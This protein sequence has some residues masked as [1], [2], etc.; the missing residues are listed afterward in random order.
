MLSNVAR[1]TIFVV[2]SL[3]SLYIAFTYSPLKDVDVASIL[4]KKIAAVN[5]PESDTLI[6][7]GE[8]VESSSTEVIVA[9][10][11]EENE[12]IKNTT[13]IETPKTA[14]TKEDPYEVLETSH[15]DTDETYRPSIS[16]CKTPMRYAFGTFDPRFNISKEKLLQI[17]KEAILVWEAAVG[18]TLFIYDEESR[19]LTINLIYDERQAST[20][21]LGYLALE[22]SNT[23]EVAENIRGAYEQEKSSYVNDSDAFNEDARR[24]Q[25]RYAAYNE[26]VK[27]YNDKGGATKVEYDAMMVELDQLK[28]DSILF[29]SRRQDLLT[30][31]EQINAKVKRYNELVAYVNTLIRKSNSMGSRTFTEGRF[32][33]LTNT[34]DIYQYSDETKLKRVLMHE[35]GHA[36]G[37]GHVENVASVMY[38]FNSGT[39][40]LLSTEDK[41]ALKEV[42]PSM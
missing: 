23:K 16:P 29:E 17:T 24:F 35:L 27:N 34:I 19:N 37:I 12:P 38:S 3:L 2:L 22:I 11:K 33:P 7:K 20:V 40:T 8:P 21:N 26:K 18:K 6:L 42:C 13:P 28:T 9:V 25:E 31:M 10:V 14:P 41:E 36:L 15:S 5:L 32:V 30:R 39:S 1:V 4:S